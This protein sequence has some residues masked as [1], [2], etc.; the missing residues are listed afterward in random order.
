MAVLSA[1]QLVFRNERANAQRGWFCI[2][3]RFDFY[4][5]SMVEADL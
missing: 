3:P 1:K 5:S 4:D 2:Y